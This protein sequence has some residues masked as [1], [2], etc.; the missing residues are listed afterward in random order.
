MSEKE[1]LHALAAL[2]D[3]VERLRKVG[4]TDGSEDVMLYVA[5]TLLQFG[6]EIGEEYSVPF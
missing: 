2:I 5:K 6:K 3:Y 1:V 4:F